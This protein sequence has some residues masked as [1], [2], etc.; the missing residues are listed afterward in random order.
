MRSITVHVNDDAEIASDR[1]DG[2][3]FD[4]FGA[5][6]SGDNCPPNT[7]LICLASQPAAFTV[8]ANF[9]EI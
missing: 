7:V 6:W 2:S 1:C 9:S 5:W 4:T 3:S 8:A